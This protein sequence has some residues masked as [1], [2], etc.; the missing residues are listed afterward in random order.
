MM[1]VYA[2][3]VSADIN[4]CDYVVVPHISGGIYQGPNMQTSE[5]FFSQLKNLVLY[6]YLPGKLKSPVRPLNHVKEVH[7]VTL[8]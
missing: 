5:E 6:H 8:Y 4:K 1:A 3:L 7:F 2:S